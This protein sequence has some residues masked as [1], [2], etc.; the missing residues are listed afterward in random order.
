MAKPI[1]E[2]HLLD[3]DKQIYGQRIS[4]EFVYKIRDEQQFTSL[5][6]LAESISDDVVLIKQW[7]AANNH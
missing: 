7:F 4:V 5:D 1:L 2:V 3:F 6:D